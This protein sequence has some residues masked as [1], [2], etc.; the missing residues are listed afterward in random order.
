MRALLLIDHG[1]RRYEANAMLECMA[2]LVQHVAGEEVVVRHAHMELSSPGI[3]E[4]F[5]AC[6]DAGAREV[7][8][9]P[10]MLSPGKHSIG[11]IPRMVSAAAEA[12]PGVSFQVTDAFGVHEKLAE[13]I[14]QR[15]GLRLTRS[16]EGS[17]PRCWQPDGA[18]GRCGPACACAR[19]ADTPAP[20]SRSSDV[21]AVSSG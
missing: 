20:A 17:T 7:I 8:V 13:L 12:F 4:G 11:D 19:D 15:A 18:I 10:Y 16:V 14:L 5:R 2:A 1:S 21:A 9:F 3:D 6:V